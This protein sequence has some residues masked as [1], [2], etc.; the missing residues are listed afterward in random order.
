MT[1]L[2]VREY[3]T[4]PG[5]VI[6]LHG[7]PGAVGDVAPIAERLGARWHVLEP[8][9]RPSGGRPL[10]VAAHV[11]DLDDLISDRCGDCRPVLVGHSWGAMLALAY[12]A[13]HPVAAASLVLI[14]CGT[15]SPATRAVF[16]A[17]VD[18]RLTSADRA[19]LA[20]I[21]QNE[22]DAGRRLAAVGRLMTQ[23]Y[24]CDLDVDG[25]GEGI[26][27]VDAQ[28]H[29]ET[30][31]DMVRLQGAGVYPAAFSAIAVPVLMLHGEADPHPGALIRDELR[32]HLPQLEYRELPTCGHSPWRE[33]QARRAFFEAL[34]TWIQGHARLGPTRS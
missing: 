23:V 27:P 6:V 8:F 22:R 13:A 11:R 20:L 24:A 15:F 34:E 10:T 30:W 5:S 32:A 26:A 14:G 17:R 3:G 33:R 9:Q 25:D 2:V 28:A 21:E 7:G 1:D 4:G 12:G 31:A 29:E 18:A 16:E 19:S